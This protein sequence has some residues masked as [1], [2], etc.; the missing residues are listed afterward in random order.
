MLIAQA[1]PLKLCIREFMEYI[2]VDFGGFILIEIILF[3]KLFVYI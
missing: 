3:H 2:L 1:F